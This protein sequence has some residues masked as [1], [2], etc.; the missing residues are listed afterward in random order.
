[1][2]FNE[3]VMKQGFGKSMIVI[4]MRVYYKWIL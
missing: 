1:M 3:D 4:I 2:D